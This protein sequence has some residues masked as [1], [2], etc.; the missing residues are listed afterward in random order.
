VTITDENATLIVALIYVA[1]VLPAV[2]L[3]LGWRAIATHR[4]GAITAIANGILTASYIWA[5]A[6][7][8]GAPVIAPHYTTARDNTIELNAAAILIAIILVIVGR[9]TRWQLLLA[10]SGTIVL[11]LY[12]GVVGSGV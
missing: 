12:L 1:F 8:V 11:W 2:P 10:G 6:V 9:R 5:F 3:V 4:P 7:V